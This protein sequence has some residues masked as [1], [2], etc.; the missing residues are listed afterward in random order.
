[1]SALQ[2]GFLCDLGD[3]AIFFLHMVVKVKAVKIISRL[4][5][6]EIER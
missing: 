1:M 5:Q 6:R 2:T 4:P 3:I